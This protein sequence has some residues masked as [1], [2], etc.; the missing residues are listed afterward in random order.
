M[1]R[2]LAAAPIEAIQAAQLIDADLC[3]DI[4]QIALGAREQHV[5]FAVGVA[6]DA[7]EAVLLDE[8][9]RSRV[10]GRNRPAFD[11]RHVLVRM[12]AEHGKIAEAADRL[13][14]IARADRMRRI[15][16]DAQAV[17]ARERVQRIEIDRQP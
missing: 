11:R 7:V 15:L 16:D 5:D 17:L 13:A 12:E 8:G 3:R 14:A 9:S 1:P 4:G 10:R 6:A 2:E